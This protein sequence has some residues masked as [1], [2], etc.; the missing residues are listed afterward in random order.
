MVTLYSTIKEQE[1]EIKESRL[2]I[3]QYAML[4]RNL[5]EEMMNNGGLAVDQNDFHLRDVTS[6]A[7]V[8]SREIRFAPEDSKY[9]SEHSIT[10][11]PQAL[12]VDKKHNGLTERM[13]KLAASM[14]DFRQRSSKTSQT[15]KTTCTE[16]YT[17]VSAHTKNMR[18]FM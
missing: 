13:K 16:V 11:P 17:P 3:T 18:D 2:K 1:D 10:F 14:T 6:N 8:E 4:I 12:K 9:S 15:S 7:A 5:E